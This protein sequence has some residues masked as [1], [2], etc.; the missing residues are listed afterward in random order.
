M[1]DEICWPRFSITLELA[2]ARNSC[3][4]MKHLNAYIWKRLYQK[5]ISHRNSKCQALGNFKFNPTIQCHTS[6]SCLMLMAM[7]IV[8]RI[9][10]ILHTSTRTHTHITWE[11]LFY[12]DFNL[13]KYAPHYQQTLVHFA[14]SISILHYLDWSMTF[15]FGLHFCSIL[16]KCGIYHTRNKKKRRR[17]MITSCSNVNGGKTNFRSL[18]SLTDTIKNQ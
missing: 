6:P 10:V 11:Q 16:S 9:H 8:K 2:E 1:L 3:D 4:R 7:H 5:F 18:H 17:K 12:S 15:G 14:R 13:E